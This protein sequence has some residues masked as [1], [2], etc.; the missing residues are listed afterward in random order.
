[1]GLRT[2]DIGCGGGFLAEE[3][4]RLG[5]RVVGVDPSAPSLETARRHAGNSGLEIDYRFG[6]G[7]DL[8]VPDGEFDVAYCCDVLEHVTDLDQVIRESA[9]ALKPG[10][11][12]FF[13]T[14]NR[15]LFS[16][17]LAIKVMQDWRTTRIFDTPLHVWEMFIKPK[18]LGL[19]MAR[20]GLRL[21]ETVGLGPRTKNPA[22]VLLGFVRASHGRMSFGEL[23]R[24]LDAGQTRTKSM[25]YMGYATREQTPSP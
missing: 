18:E 6:S 16:K 14:V 3:F 17:L 11:I 19:T 9:R 4:A 25:S 20:H 7:E 10:G 1:L 13:D 15:T 22:R 8:P 24:R 21:H 23:S 2:L 12:Y 5:C